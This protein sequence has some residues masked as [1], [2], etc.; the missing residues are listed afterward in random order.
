MGF[1]ADLIQKGEQVGEEMLSLFQSAQTREDFAQ[2]LFDLVNEVIALGK[3]VEA[4]EP[5]VTAPA[6][7]SLAERPDAAPSA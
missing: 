3:R 7:A 5:S 1:I 2:H 6:P 4:L